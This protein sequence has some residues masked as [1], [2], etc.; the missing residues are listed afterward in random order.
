MFS[1]HKL[2]FG[3][4]GQSLLIALIFGLAMTLNGQNPAKNQIKALKID[5]HTAVMTNN[6]EVV[7]QHIAAGSKLNE[8]EPSGGSSPL[9]MAAAFGK[10]EIAKLLIQAGADLKVQNNDGSTALHNAAFFCRPEIAKMLLNKGADKMTKNK[11]GQT[12]R[13]TV[14]GPFAEVKV[15][16]QQLG[17]MLEPLGL[18]LD[19]A[20]IEKTRP[21]MAAML[22]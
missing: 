7:K 18:K 11:Y 16:Y 15:F 9:I 4:A 17:T 21:K 14:A 8:K 22:K 13:E 1:K 10:T 12:A 20:Y 6:I 3:L 19:L 5:L 2:M